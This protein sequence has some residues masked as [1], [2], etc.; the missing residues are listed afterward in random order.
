VGFDAIPVR[1]IG[2]MYFENEPA[3]PSNHGLIYN[4]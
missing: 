1:F 2:H 3:L 4:F